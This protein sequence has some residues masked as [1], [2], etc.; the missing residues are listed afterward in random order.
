MGVPHC[1]VQGTDTEIDTQFCLK[2]ITQTV[3]HVEGCVNIFRKNLSRWEDTL[4]ITS[5][6]NL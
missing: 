5:K 3:L 1:E 4:K 2:I 6:E